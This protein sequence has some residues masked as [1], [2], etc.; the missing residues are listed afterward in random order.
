MTI[1]TPIKEAE[2]KRSMQINACLGAASE[3]VLGHL[4]NI[5]RGYDIRGTWGTVE[6]VCNPWGWIE[7]DVSGYIRSV[8]GRKLTAVHE[9]GHC[10]SAFMLGSYPRFARVMLSRNTD[11]RGYVYQGAWI[12]SDTVEAVKQSVEDRGFTQDQVLLVASCQI[13]ELFSGYAAE[14]CVGGLLYDDPEWSNDIRK[15]E[16]IL[17]VYPDLNQPDLWDLAAALVTYYAD[18]VRSIAVKLYDRV[19]LNTAE[20]LSAAE[21]GF[22]PNFRVHPLVEW[23]FNKLPSGAGLIKAAS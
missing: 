3:D 5:R 7:R 19:E 11:L 2:A 1:C 17:E 15:A 20:L 18:A 13:I 6:T 16:N 4:R 23:R 10:V 9:A 21:D 12:Y 14:T 22:G 8:N